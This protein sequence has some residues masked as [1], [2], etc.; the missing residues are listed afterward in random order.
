MHVP[1]GAAFTETRDE[2]LLTFWGQQSKPVPS[3]K[4]LQQ[5]T[6]THR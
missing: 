3:T 6:R 2:T 4:P 1:D 5:G